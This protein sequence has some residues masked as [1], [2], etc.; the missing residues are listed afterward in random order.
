MI[1]VNDR[2]LRSITIG[3][4]GEKNGIPRDTGFDIT[5]ASELMAILLAAG[6]TNAE[7]IKSLRRRIGQMV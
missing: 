4:G 6:S 3:Q 7:A 2:F 1:D 5:V